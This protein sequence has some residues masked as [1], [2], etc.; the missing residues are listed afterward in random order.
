[1][2]FR[3]TPTAVVGTYTRSALALEMVLTFRGRPLPFQRAS[4]YVSSE[5]CLNEPIFIQ[6]PTSF[7]N[8]NPGVRQ[9]ECLA[10]KME[11]TVTNNEHGEGVVVSG[12]GAGSAAEEGILVGDII[13]AVNDRAVHDHASAIEEMHRTIGQVTTLALLGAV[14]NRKVVLNKSLGKIGITV[15]NRADGHG[16]EVTGLI[17]HGIAAAEGVA[18]GDV[19]LSVNGHLVSDHA[20]AIALID[21]SD[22]LIEMVLA[23]TV[24]LLARRHPPPLCVDGQWRT[25]H[26]SLIAAQSLRTGGGSGGQ[27][28]PHLLPLRHRHGSLS[29]LAPRRTGALATHRLH[30]PGEPGRDA[31]D[32]APPHL[33]DGG[34]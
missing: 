32:D 26:V 33:T 24:R 29:F 9:V 10:K 4:K 18:V 30:R 11:I 19:V 28:T 12:L 3:S 8:G 6:E 15:T 20:H 31:C 13:L 1:M 5:P 7:A 27:S 2:E 34:I 16:V 21:S 25:K 17:L 14:P 22:L 23:A